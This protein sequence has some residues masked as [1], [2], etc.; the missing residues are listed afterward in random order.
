MQIRAAGERYERL[1]GRSIGTE[2]SLLRR[3]Q[4][5]RLV[6]QATP[7]AA[8]DTL[9]SV[10]SEGSRRFTDRMSQSFRRLS[11]LPLDASPGMS[12]PLSPGQT[13]R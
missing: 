8:L 7:S 13:L 12:G 2:D 11:D 6:P 10:S 4:E 3:L 5:A 9:A 1:Y